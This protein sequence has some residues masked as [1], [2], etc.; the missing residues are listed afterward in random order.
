MNVSDMVK[1]L[2]HLADMTAYHRAMGHADMA[3]LFNGRYDGYRQAL[4]DMGYRV[5]YDHGTAS[6]IVKK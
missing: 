4:A 3:N 6:D 5:I 1:T 2:N